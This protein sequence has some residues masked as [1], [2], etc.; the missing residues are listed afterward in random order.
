VVLFGNEFWSG[1]LNWLRGS[2]LTR[3]LILEEDF[4]L[5]RICDEPDEVV[6]TVQSWYS[7]HRMVGKNAELQAASA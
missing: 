6:S 1:F 2:V 3:G 5:L 4:S 7:K